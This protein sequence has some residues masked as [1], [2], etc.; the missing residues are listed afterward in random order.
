MMENNTLPIQNNKALFKIV[1]FLNIF[2]L[3]TTIIRKTKSYS[4]SIQKVLLL[5]KVAQ[6][7]SLFK[8]VIIFKRC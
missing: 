5:M 7:E 8:I 1:K 4:N 3:T 6:H 2:N